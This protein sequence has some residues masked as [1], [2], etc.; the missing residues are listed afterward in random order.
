MLQ[1][2]QLGQTGSVVGQT[3]FRP[4]TSLLHKEIKSGSVIPEGKAAKKETSTILERFLAEEQLRG[5]RPQGIKDL[6][7]RVRS[8]LDYAENREL[9]LSCLSLSDAYAY[10]GYQ[11]ARGNA[12]SDEH[13]QRLSR[14]TVL[15][16]VVAA[17]AF[18]AYLVRT[19]A[20]LDNP[21]THIRRVRPERRLP[22]DVLKE[23]E[24]GQLLSA[25]ES[26]NSSVNLKAASRRYLVHV[27]AELAYATGL[28]VAEL[29]Q[30]TV[31]DI[32]FE[33]A[34]VYVRD[35]K[36]G[37]KRIAFMN[38]YARDVL[39]WYTLRLRPLLANGQRGANAH[40]LFLSS[41]DRLGHVL[42][43]ELALVAATQS[44]PAT[45]M[46]GFR[47]AVG[48]HLLRAGC[49]IRHIQAI[50]GHKAIKDTEIYTKVDVE[51]VCSTLERFHP[52]A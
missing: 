16:Y 12:R 14:R 28:R 5:R 22:K 10:Q 35:G 4:V 6:R 9:D 40:R 3:H 43:E 25:L 44:L 21:F 34:Y 30:L 52:R 24:V 2:G 13:G 7:S 17:H 36:K 42:N 29:A 15:S 26:W 19:G 31:E 32:D 50:L 27:V 37:S 51:G 39:E 47:H 18:C 46:H 38:D 8:F 45:T 20:A 49:G 33:R 23:T 11:A 48:Y 41:H 1:V